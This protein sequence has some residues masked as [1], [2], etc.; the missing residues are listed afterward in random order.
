MTVSYIEVYEF[1]YFRFN[2]LVLPVQRIWS[3]HALKPSDDT[4]VTTKAHDVTIYDH[5]K[6]SFGKNRSMCSGEIKMN[7][8][9]LLFEE[10][11]VT[12]QAVKHRYV[13]RREK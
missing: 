2:D 3:V 7:R 11:I 6:L 9:G 8:K 1:I 4:R 10:S 5:V 13:T 12:A